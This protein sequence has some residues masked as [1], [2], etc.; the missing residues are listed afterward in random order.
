M[1]NP[2]RMAC[3]FVIVSLA[4]CS[5]SQPPPFR[6]GVVREPDPSVLTAIG[7]PK[8]G[9]TDSS[10]EAYRLL[11]G[12]HLETRWVIYRLHLDD[13]EPALLVRVVA[14]GT[15][16]LSRETRLDNADV[17]RLRRL[18]HRTGFWQ[19]ALVPHA[20]GEGMIWNHVSLEGLRDGTALYFEGIPALEL[21]AFKPIKGECV[22]IA[23]SENDIDS[24]LAS[25]CD[26]SRRSS[27]RLNPTVGSVTG[28]AGARPAPAPPE[29]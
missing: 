28:L 29:G 7:E 12:N 18:I 13:T 2:A 14:C 3:L 15:E 20:S 4:A 11:F 8:L 22:R 1:L 23:D 16:R 9:N 26:D 17:R 27:F 19:G 24:L 6:I 5:C 25:P 10:G 21:A